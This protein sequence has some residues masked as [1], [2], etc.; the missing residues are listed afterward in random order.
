[1]IIY[2][3]ILIFTKKKKKTISY[4]MDKNMKIPR[5]REINKIKIPCKWKIFGKYYQKR[6]FLCWSS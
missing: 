5:G 3:R 2:S 4:F 6:S 1:M